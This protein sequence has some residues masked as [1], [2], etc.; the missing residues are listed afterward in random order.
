MNPLIPMLAIT[1]KPDKA[2]MDKIFKQYRDVNI[3]QVV[4]YPRSGCEFTYPSDEW[5][6]FCKMFVSTA[7]E[8]NLK[9]WLYDDFNW[10]SAQMN[11]YLLKKYPDKASQYIV[12]L[13]DGSY[14]IRRKKTYSDILDDDITDAFIENTH[15]RYFNDFGR[16]FGS[17]VLGF[18]TDEPSFGYASE[19]V[20]GKITAP[21]YTG[22][23]EDYEATYNRSFSGDIK[24]NYEDFWL[25]YYKLLGQRFKKV[26]ISKVNDWCVSHDVVLTGHMMDESSIQGAVRDNGDLLSVLSEMSHPGID[27]IFTFIS[28]E[29]EEVETLAALR[30]ATKTGKHGLVEVFAVGPCDM[31]VSR[32]RQMI[33]LTSLFGADHFVMTVAAVDARGNSIKNQYY[34]PNNY[35]QPWFSAYKTLGAEIES[36]LEYRDAPFKPQVQV[37]YPLNIAQKNIKTP[38]VE[39]INLN[40]KKLLVDLTQKQVDWEV[41]NEG[42]IP[43]AD[44][45]F[46][47]DENGEFGSVESLKPIYPYITDRN[48]ELLLDVYVKRFTDGRF[49][50]LDGGDNDEDRL[51]T[52]H[53]VAGKVDT[54]LYARGIITDK[55]LAEF[56][57]PIKTVASNFE[58][59]KLHSKN[60]FRAILVDGDFKFTCQ[61]DLKV[62]IIARDYKNDGVI[63]LDGEVITSPNCCRLLTDGFNELYKVSREITLKKGE[64]VL[65]SSGAEDYR[66]LPLC[67]LAG[68]FALN[69][70][71]CIGT[72]NDDILSGDITA[73]L[74]NYVGSVTAEYSVNIPN[75]ECNLT[76]D[77]GSFYTKVLVDGEYIGE[78]IFPG[79]KITVPQK[80]YGKTVKVEC[81]IF[82]SVAP[83]FYDVTRYDEAQPLEWWTRF[84][85]IVNPGR[86]SNI[87][88]GELQLNLL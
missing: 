69:G 29:K 56:K 33:C 32:I 18:F 49:I 20:E 15:Q 65:S 52:V 38:L 16:F 86:F 10:P 58:K 17:T 39:K 42:D 66:Y 45:V 71:N 4:L 63:K 3:D 31:P 50:I 82:T 44:V 81:E 6:D 28:P 64:H 9:V 60:L 59:I 14:E 88:I 68:D 19:N 34:N 85:Y 22:L 70:N 24:E 23:N 77:F 76:G 40:Y 37:V 27:E 75:G 61:D 53:T 26:F 83:L 54:I 79:D 67:I 73:A 30:Y 5:Y 55:N 13:D 25:N 80:F 12:I 74:K 48:G 43:T 41:I 8:N 62:N 72:L 46:T 11:G 1:G 84:D 2:K 87:K 7:A 51:V 57:A 78:L 36:I 21:Y 35:M 47:V